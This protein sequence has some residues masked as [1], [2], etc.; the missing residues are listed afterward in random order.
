MTAGLFLSRAIVASVVL[1]ALYVV[2]KAAISRINAPA[3]M[4]SAILAIYTV[5]ILAAITGVP[6]PASPASGQIA[7]INAVADESASSISI[8]R[9]AVIIY[10]AGTAIMLLVTAVAWF[11]VWR[12]VAR[13]SK[14]TDSRGLKITLLDNDTYS[15]FSWMGRIVM[16]RRDY[17]TAPAAVLCHE[18]QHVTLRHR[19]D[20]AIAQIFLILDWFNPA[21]WLLL[22]QLRK[23]HEYQADRRVLDSGADKRDYQLLLISRAARCRFPALANALSRSPLRD[24]IVM[25]QRDATKRAAW[26]LLFLLPG[27]LCA[28]F[29]LA[30]PVVSTSLRELNNVT[31]VNKPQKA[32]GTP[33]VMIGGELIPMEDM[34]KVDASQIESIT[35]RKDLPG[36][37]DGLIIVKMKE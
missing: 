13:G 32:A 12:M 17:E 20:L 5:S 15:P 19:Y 29:V 10:L 34:E 18:M 7:A 33:D 16:S 26:R 27:L 3:L 24:R 21:A 30:S 25:M 9:I 28:G 8:T 4:R 35:V 36:H 11:R 14:V 6:H 31:A 22:R 1:S 2:Y 23:V 37:P